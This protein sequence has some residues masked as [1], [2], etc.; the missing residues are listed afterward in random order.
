MRKIAIVHAKSDNGSLAR[1]ANAFAV[2]ARS[3][4][5]TATLLLVTEPLTETFW[6]TLA[7]MDVIVFGSIASLTG[8]RPDF[9]A[10]AEQSMLA[11]GAP[12]WSGK[13]AG[14]FA[15]SGSGPEEEIATMRYLEALAARQKMTWL[16]PETAATFVP[17]PDQSV[18]DRLESWR[19]SMVQS[20]AG[21]VRIKGDLVAA[22]RY[23][24]LLAQAAHADQGGGAPRRAH[25]L[26]Q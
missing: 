18:A 7:P 14:G 8:S 19:A 11:G 6:S 5:G 23:G 22:E 16:A 9:E 12:R 25:T 4:R 26:P 2:G 21:E 24:K 17:P 13:I 10:F 1:L 3:V 20:S 15:S